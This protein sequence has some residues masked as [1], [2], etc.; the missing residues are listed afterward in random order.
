MSL[1]Q[2]RRTLLD[3]RWTTI[4][5]AAG[6]AG[7]GVLIVLFW[8]TMKKSEQLYEQL[9]TA[10][11]EAMLK[12]FGIE[13]MGRFTGFLGTEYLNF[14]WPLI[15]AVFLVMAASSAVAGEIDR[16]TVELWLS[17]PV[18]RWRLLLAKQVA[19]LLEI[20]VLSAATVLS[21]AVGAVLVG[22]EIP[23]GGLV[24]PAVVLASFCIAV[25]GYTVLFSSLV[26]SRGAA[27]GLGAAVTLASYLAGVLSSLSPDVERLKYLSLVTAFHPQRA[28]E[29][30]EYAADVLILIAIGVVCAA[31]SLVV[32][33]R[34]DANP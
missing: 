4:W 29:G 34:R 15:A 11:P 13:G 3:Q 18:R 20:V 2:L 24:A 1:P 32:F 31:L 10:F 26:S 27:A 17:V 25:G 22:E 6:I 21:V 8:P 9:L 5:F 7:Y 33:E 19:L 23:R 12:A 28:L 14:M 30:G 16:G